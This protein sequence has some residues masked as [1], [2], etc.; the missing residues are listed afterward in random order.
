MRDFAPPAPDFA[1]LHPGYKWYALS[2]RSLDDLVGQP[3]H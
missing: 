2:I 1:S 3:I